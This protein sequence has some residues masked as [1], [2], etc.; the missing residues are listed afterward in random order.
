MRKIKIFSDPSLDV[1]TQHVNS[2]GEDNYIVDVSICEA[3]NSMRC[4]VLYVDPEDLVDNEEE[5][6]EDS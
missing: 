5:D 1:I 6:E 2:F 3:R 4:V